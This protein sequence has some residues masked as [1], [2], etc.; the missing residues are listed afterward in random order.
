VAARHLTTLP[1]GH[2]HKPNA[3]NK[4]KAHSR[5]PWILRVHISRNCL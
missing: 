1:R 4:K 2:N 3:K 5:I